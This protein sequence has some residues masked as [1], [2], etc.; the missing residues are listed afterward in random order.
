M[1]WKSCREGQNCDDGS[2]GT[3]VRVVMMVM[4]PNSDCDIGVMLLILS[5]IL[6][7]RR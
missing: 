5:A 1:W 2:I 3:V 6:L 4:V 7:T